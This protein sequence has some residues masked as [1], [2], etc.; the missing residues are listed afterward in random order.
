M[1]IEKILNEHETEQISYLNDL[2]IKSE[3]IRFH[4]S[5][6][7]MSLYEELQNEKRFNNDEIQLFSETKKLYTITMKRI[8]NFKD[9]NFMKIDK[10]N[11]ILDRIKNKEEEL[12][13]EMNFI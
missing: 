7:F 8:I 10:I 5:I 12:D 3:N 4:D 11:L 2:I 9:E 6:F 1:K 13:K